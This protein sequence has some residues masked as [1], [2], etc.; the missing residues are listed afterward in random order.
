M[1]IMIIMITRIIM[2]MTIISIIII[3]I[4]IIA[5]FFFFSYWAKVQSPT[6]CSTLRY[7]TLHFPPST[8]PYPSDHFFELLFDAYRT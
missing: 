8:L 7:A 3:I 5:I 4:V 1:I 6:H 2:I